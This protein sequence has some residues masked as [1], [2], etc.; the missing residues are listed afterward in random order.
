MKNMDKMNLSKLKNQADYRRKRLKEEGYDGDAVPDKKLV[1]VITLPRNLKKYKDA[2]IK[3][4]KMTPILKDMERVGIEIPEEVHESIYEKTIQRL[5][6]K[7]RLENDTLIRKSY[8]NLS[9]KFRDRLEEE[10]KTKD[11]KVNNDYIQRV[12]RKLEVMVEDKVRKHVEITKTFTNGYTASY[13]WGQ[14]SV[15]TTEKEIEK[16]LARLEDYQVI[17]VYDLYQNGTLFSDDS[18]YDSDQA[19]MTR[20]LSSALQLIQEGF[21]VPRSGIHPKYGSVRPEE[22]ENKYEWL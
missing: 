22:L 9:K 11:A 2:A 21:N 20:Y 1:E 17:F 14:K 5:R 8:N 7:E 10:T 12:R 19:N 18:D 13:H 3:S 4:G 6:K 15:N 16:A